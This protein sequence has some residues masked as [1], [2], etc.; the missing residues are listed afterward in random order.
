M[1]MPMIMGCDAPECAYNTEG[2]C[3]ALAITVGDEMAAM[4]DTFCNM[5]MSAGDPDANGCVGACKMSDCNQNQ[6]L[7]CVAPAINVGHRGSE[8]DCLTYATM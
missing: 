4:C 6:R 1:E 3:H 2:M 8:I 7:E 5:S